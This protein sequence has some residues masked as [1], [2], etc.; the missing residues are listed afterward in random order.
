MFKVHWGV[1][2]VTLFAILTVPISIPYCNPYILFGGYDYLVNSRKKGYY[3]VRTKNSDD[4]K[5]KTEESEDYFKSL[6]EGR[7][8][9]PMYSS[10]PTAEEI[11]KNGLYVIGMD[12]KEL[13]TEEVQDQ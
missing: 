12:P 1:R 9:C 11:K 5:V 6:E 7:I 10:Y 13:E 2:L 8:Y 3:L 4:V